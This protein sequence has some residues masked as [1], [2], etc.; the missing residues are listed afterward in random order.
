MM[1]CPWPCARPVRAGQR[2]LWLDTIYGDEQVCGACARDQ[3]G[4][5]GYQ[6]DG[7]ILDIRQ[8][9]RYQQR[10]VSPTRKVGGDGRGS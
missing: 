9:V 7:T 3:R 4:G 1:M 5:Y 8:T 6:A 2:G 10:Y